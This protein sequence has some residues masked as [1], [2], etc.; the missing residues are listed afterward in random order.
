MKHLSILV[1]E[2]NS[3][4]LAKK[5]GFMTHSIQRD[6]REDGVDVGPSRDG[7]WEQAGSPLTGPHT[8]SVPE[9]LVNKH[10]HSHFP[11]PFFLHTIIIEYLWP[12]TMNLKCMGFKQGR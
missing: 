12:G 8:T 7:A 10:K 5:P 4:R 6:N 3:T 2:C 11:Q 9:H 1:S